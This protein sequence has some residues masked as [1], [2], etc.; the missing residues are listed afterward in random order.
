MRFEETFL[1]DYNMPTVCKVISLK[2]SFKNFNRDIFPILMEK[3]MTNF[4]VN[5]LTLI[6]GNY[7]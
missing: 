5:D 6:E 4:H 1:N 3:I 7:L 2:S